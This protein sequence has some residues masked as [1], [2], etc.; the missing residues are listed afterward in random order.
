[1]ASAAPAMADAANDPVPFIAA[2]GVAG[3]SDPA[4]ADVLWKQV[5]H[6]LSQG[7]QY[8]NTIADL[9]HKCARLETV[10]KS[11]RHELHGAYRRQHT[12]EATKVKLTSMVEKLTSM[13]EAQRVVLM[14]QKSDAELLSK[15]KRLVSVTPGQLP[16]RSEPG[17]AAPPSPAPSANA[18]GD[19]NF[20]LK[21][22]Y[23]KKAIIMDDK[24]GVVFEATE[25]P[26]DARN[27]RRREEYARNKH[28]R[29]MHDKGTQ[30]DRPRPLDQDGFRTM[31]SASGS[32]A[33]SSGSGDGVPSPAAEPV[34]CMSDDTILDTEDGGP[35][36]KKRK[37]VQL[38]DGVN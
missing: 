17:E 33:A 32:S 28:K 26:T 27:R 16:D 25:N 1:M 15:I 8:R 13:V 5:Q 24:R 37:Q 7:A 31:A 20:H 22:H 10:E 34:D 38:L 21:V 4:P 3:G 35:P 29:L 18:Q 11:M 12:D 2:T 30:E 14:H 6:L 23:S 36:I 9:E 19:K